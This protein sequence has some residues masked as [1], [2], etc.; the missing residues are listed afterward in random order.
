MGSYKIS[1]ACHFGA[2]STRVGV[3]ILIRDHEGLVVV[4]AGF[5]LQKYADKISNFSFAV[6]Y[7]L[8]LAN[9]TGFRDSIVLEV[10]SRTILSHQQQPQHEFQSQNTHTHSNVIIKIPQNRTVINPNIQFC[11]FPTRLTLQKQGSETIR[12][13]SPFKNL[14]CEFFEGGC[15]GGGWWLRGG[16]KSGGAAEIGAQRC[17][18]AKMGPEVPV[19]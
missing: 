10:P 11:N 19:R 6:F 3:G 5:V 18:H 13:S 12:T 1:I 7:A 8:Q 15:H 17:Q 9:E 14:V 16:L 4:A 2:A